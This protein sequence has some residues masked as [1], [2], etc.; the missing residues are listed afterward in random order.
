MNI[1]VETIKK[2]KRQEI[3]GIEVIEKKWLVVSVEERG[4]SGRVLLIRVRS[5][6]CESW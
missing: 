6:C 1:Y 3:L 5:S 2:M 4:T